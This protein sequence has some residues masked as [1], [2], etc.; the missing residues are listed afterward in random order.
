MKET[1]S[2]IEGDAGKGKVIIVD[3]VYATGGTMDA[4]EELCKQAG[5]EVLGK[6]VFID[7]AFLHGSTD[8]RSVI[9]YDS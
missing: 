8:V 4:A 2:P 9:K 5:Y 7:L 1:K 6:L 3:D